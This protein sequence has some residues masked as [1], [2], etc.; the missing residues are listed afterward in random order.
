MRACSGVRDS[1]E[2]MVALG[3]DLKAWRRSHHYNI[4]FRPQRL[5]FALELVVREQRRGRGL[6]LVYFQRGPGERWFSQEEKRRVLGLESFL[7]D[8]FARSSEIDTP[9]TDS[10]RRGLIIADTEGKLLHSSTEGRRLLF[11]ATHP[12]LV[13][14]NDFG[15]V[16]T[17][18]VALVR[19][20]TDLAGI[21]SGD[22][23]VSA[24]S[25]SCRNVWGG[26]TVHAN[27]LEGAGSSSS[28]V[29]ITIS[30]QE[31][32]PI[33]LTRSAEHLRLSR[34]Q[35]EVC[36]LMATGA[37]IDK[38]A[39]RLGISKHTAVAHGRSIYEQLRVH[40]RT[41]LLNRL[42]AVV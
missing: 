24:P 17:L 28:L 37:T 6:G 31:P 41:E 12:R 23:S 5:D 25:Y 40:N 35:T 11:L 9:M 7:A 29:G 39:E 38:I 15:D 4:L 33:R 30:H 19:L 27:W 13:P 8:G 32:L 21:F 20:C 34:R 42:L 36:L 26:F 18:P 10:G 3:S 1:E 2:I 22:L 14:G 16:D